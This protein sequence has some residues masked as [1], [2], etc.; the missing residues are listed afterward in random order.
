MK[1]SKA[2]SA[3]SLALMS[4]G[5]A[6]HVFAPTYTLPIPFG[7]YASGAAA[8][9]VASFVIVGYVLKEPA[10]RAPL[11]A[12]RDD[13]GSA[14]NG[15]LPA[16]I[17]RSLSFVSVFGLLLTIATGLFGSPN[18]LV[19]FNMT[20]FWIVFVLGFTYATVLVGDIYALMNPWRAI[21]DGLDRISPALFRGRLRYPAWLGYYPALALYMAFI[22]IEL[23]GRT[24][25]RTLSMTLIAYSGLT[26]V[27]AW[28]FGKENWFRFGEFFA[29]MFRLIGKMA[30]LAY[31]R[32]SN[33]QHPYR[34]QLRRPFTGLL[35]GSADHASLLLFVI[36]MLS[37]TAYDGAHN[38]LP[39]VGIFWKGIHPV[40]STVFN[41]PYFFFVK[42][43]YAWQSAMLFLLP[44]VYLAIYLLLLW[45]AKVAAQSSIPLRTLA[46]RFAFTLIPIALVY[47]LTHYYML[48]FSQGAQ[49]ARMISDPFS[50]GWNLF[51]TADW[52]ADP[53]ILDAG[54]VWHTQVALILFGHI[55]SVYLA[56]V[57]A[58]KVFGN[59]RH[60][61]LSQLPMLVLMVL[62]TTVGLW[63]LSLPI[64]AGS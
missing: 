56:H 57:E 1:T 3:L 29:V 42:I 50:L 49:I 31:M 9:L 7:M 22:W 25:P 14:A 19:N 64:A 24:Q 53:I 4:D 38:T 37:S 55:V 33:R 40:L 48:L 21:C 51:G 16:W 47:S 43:Y 35:D 46:L 18:A 15:M 20:F 2:A 44:L 61:M 17:V 32:T 62:L 10:P 13:G 27:A 5:V 45:L 58:L 60:A 26:L 11:Q 8:A 36:F 59:R 12:S 23:F 6:A 54:G 28:L 52:S 63:I 39:W 34:V 30:P 41:Q